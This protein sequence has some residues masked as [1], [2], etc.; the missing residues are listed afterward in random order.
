MKIYLIEKN[1]NK[2]LY[3]Y[4]KCKYVV[5]N[6]KEISKAKVILVNKVVNVKEAL[7]IIDFALSIGIEVVCIKNNFA[8]EYYVCN[9]LIKDGA[10]YV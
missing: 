5:V 9:Y 4:L 10:I 2:E 6:K 8:K 1:N 7:E 3:N